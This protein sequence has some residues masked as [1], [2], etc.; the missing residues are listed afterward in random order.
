MI[1]S[2]AAARKLIGLEEAL[3][4]PRDDVIRTHNRRM[5]PRMMSVY[6]FIGLN[7]IPAR[8]QG[9]YFWDTDGR[10]YTDFLSAF[11]TLAF[12]HNP[13]RLLDALQ[14]VQSAGI[15]NL[16]EGPSRLAAALAENLCSLAPRGLERVYFANS[17]TE[18]IDAAIKMAR[19][20]TGRP[21][22]VAC[23]KAYHGRSIAALSVSDRREY[24]ENFEPL[25]PQVRFVDFGDADALTGE[26]AARDVAGFLVEPLQ[27]ESGMN[28]APPGYLAAARQVCSRYGT[29]LIF[30]EIQC[31]LGRTGKFL[32]ADHDDVIPDCVLLGK[33]LG[34]GVMPLSALL[35]T[36]EIF[37]ASKGDAPQSPFHVS[38]YAAN[39]YAC[40]VGIAALE[41]LVDEGLIE[42]AADSGNYFAARLNELKSR[43]PVIAAIR[44]KGLMLGV[45]LKPPGI[46]RSVA[47]GAFGKQ[48][49][50]SDARYLLSGVV[51]RELITRRGL[52][53]AITLHNADVIRVQPPL[54][55][56][57]DVI[58]EFIDGLDDTLTQVKSYARTVWKSAPDII[59]F[60]RSRSVE[61]AYE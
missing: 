35:T 5:N 56:T 47:S 11:G 12:G 44:G 21:A 41:A 26:L 59:N 33:A 40:A 1:Q 55:V 22:I 31:G 24:R 52:V 36:N 7:N 46:L 29:I 34:G 50:N 17:G 10:R 45:E 38:T 54:N 23:R 9:P 37:T 30:D 3:S 53:T 18:T 14:R 60:L 39:S 32:A 61:T 28:N 20:A 57:R 43:Q 15:P 8:A 51:L 42:R 2:A 4:R 16:V 58:D 25:L 49:Q 19:A 48:M 27:G 13:Q 6:E